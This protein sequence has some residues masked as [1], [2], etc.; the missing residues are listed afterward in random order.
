[1]LEELF[2][3]F[4]GRPVYKIEPWGFCPRVNLE[5]NVGIDL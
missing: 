4:V 1:M 3:C 2:V 5:Q